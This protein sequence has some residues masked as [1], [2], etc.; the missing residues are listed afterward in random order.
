MSALEKI[1]NARGIDDLAAEIEPL[2]QAMAKLT[3]EARQ[4][5]EEVEQASQRQANEWQKKQQQVSAEWVAVAKSMNQAANELAEA[6]ATA[7]RAARGWTWKLW[8][9]VILASL[10][11]TVVLLI[12]SWL[13]LSPQV[14]TTTEGVTW[15]ILKLN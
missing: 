8:A 1:K 7:N 14:T 5:I 6:S 12:A 3:D 4:R 2:A 15:L 9:G 13:W 10:M 11:P